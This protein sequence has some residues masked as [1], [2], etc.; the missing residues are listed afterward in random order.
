MICCAVWP[1]APPRPNH[2]VTFCQKRHLLSF[3]FEKPSAAVS[4]G[5]GGAGRLSTTG[6]ATSG[7]AR[8]LG[9]S[10]I[11]FRRIAI[12]PLCVDTASDDHLPSLMYLPRA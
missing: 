3:A 5:I 8:M 12:A 11:S 2:K 4:C 9:S 10:S 6:A 1:A 7:A